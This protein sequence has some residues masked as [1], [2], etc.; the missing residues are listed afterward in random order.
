MAY[1]LQ[2]LG[3]NL[4]IRV[5]ETL[6][7]FQ[8]EMTAILSQAAA[9]GAANSSRVYV[10]YSQHGIN[11]LKASINDAAQFAY[12]LTGEHTGEVFTQ[13]EHCTKLMIDA[14][15]SAIIVRAAQSNQYGQ[16][17]GKTRVAFQDTAQSLLDDFRN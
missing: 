14:M 15:M 3:R 9:H 2:Y 12:N 8:K 1:D 11:V 5:R 10:Q 17:I 6:T 13:V 16:I 7:A 4:T